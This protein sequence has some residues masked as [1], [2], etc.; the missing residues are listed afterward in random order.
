MKTIK[1]YEKTEPVKLQKLLKEYEKC[2]EKSELILSNM[3]SGNLEY[4]K[5]KNKI[6]DYEIDISLIRME[7]N[8][9][10]WEKKE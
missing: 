1:I 6:A 5:L 10:L 4:E 2:L 9:R 3:E 8:K 7:L